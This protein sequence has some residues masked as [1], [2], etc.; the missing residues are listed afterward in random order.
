MTEEHAQDEPAE[1]AAAAAA[2]TLKLHNIMEAASALT[3]LGDEEAEEQDTTVVVEEEKT[4]VVVV[5]VVEQ[6]KQEQT[7]VGSISTSKYDSEQIK[8]QESTPDGT[9]AQV[10]IAAADNAKRFIP[11]HKKPDAALTFPE[12]V[13]TLFNGYFFHCSYPSC[14]VEE[15]YPS[16]RRKYRTKKKCVRFTNVCVLRRFIPI[17]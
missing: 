16:E 5:A 17:L 3:A 11:E 10:A 13:S 15:T 1:L 8:Q 12:K 4:A 9:V 14:C 7:S 2:P 6:K